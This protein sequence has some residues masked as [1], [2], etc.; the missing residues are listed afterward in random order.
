[1]NIEQRK[2]DHVRLSASGEA[3]YVKTAGFER[4]DF[5]HSA[6]P[7][8]DFNEI[9]TS[10]DFL[11]YE[12]G[13]PLFI[14]SMTGGYVEAG[15]VNQIIAGFCQDKRIPFGVGSQ[16]IMLDQ[17]ETAESFSIVR[18]EAPDAFI[19]SNIGGCQI[20]GGLSASQL[21][22]LT[23]TIE[24]NAI[25]VHLNVLQ[26]LMQ[27]EGDRQFRGILEGITDLINRTDLPVI[28]KE[29]GAGIS[30][31][32]ARQLM[33]CGVSVI[34]VSG[35]GGTSWSKI[36]NQRR[37]LHGS[38]F[39]EWGIPTVDCILQAREKGVPKE[40][41]IASGG[42]RSVTEMGKA[43][44]LGAG[45]TA[46]A[47]PVIRQINEGGRDALEMWYETLA[48]EFKIIL[49]LLGCRKVSELSEDHIRKVDYFSK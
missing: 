48:H 11:G 41:L 15:K 1:M 42:V 9:E 16:R 6:L 44:C 7:E 49:C 39:D 3:A 43:L 34:D 24:A 26:E 30:G 31:Q 45:F 13:F 21:K 17:P 23:D 33:D 36:E 5:N 37:S 35:S 20:I 2:K 27:P 22:L 14:S 38:A 28:V 18:R 40:Q 19:A 10:V 47:Q 25:I 46:M 8:V 29:T 12:A 32:T 4:F